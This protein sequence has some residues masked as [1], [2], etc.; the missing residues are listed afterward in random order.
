M[1]DGIRI[2]VQDSKEAVDGARLNLSAGLDVVEQVFI[3]AGEGGELGDIKLQLLPER[4][5]GGWCQQP[6]CSA[7]RVVTDATCFAATDYFAA[8][9]TN[10]HRHI[11]CDDRNGPPI[12]Q[13][14]EQFPATF[15]PQN[16][17]VTYRA[18]RRLLT[19][20]SRVHDDLVER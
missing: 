13:V 10:F 20:R 7:N 4:P 2:L 12:A 15:S 18:T 6:E 1:G 3:D 16:A 14:V 17:A 9:V 5:H 19:I 11:L 8:G